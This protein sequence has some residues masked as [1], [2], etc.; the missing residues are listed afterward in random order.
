MM[1]PLQLHRNNL[2]D[3]E[4][5]PYP[6]QDPETGGQ[7]SGDSEVRGHMDQ[8]DLISPPSQVSRLDGLNSASIKL[9]QTH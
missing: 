4:N 7:D 9:A 3:G 5:S 2:N 8:S 1:T 6:V